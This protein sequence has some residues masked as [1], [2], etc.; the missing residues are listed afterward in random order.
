MNIMKIKNL[1]KFVKMNMQNFH[2]TILHVFISFQLKKMRKIKG[3]CPFMNK[4][5]II[6]RPIFWQQLKENLLKLKFYQMNKNS[7]LIYWNC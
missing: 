2:K 6:L 5:F 1:N 4:S 7:M 3:F